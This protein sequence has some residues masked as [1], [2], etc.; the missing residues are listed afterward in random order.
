[1]LIF[2]CTCSAQIC[3]K[4]RPSQSIYRY[5]AAGSRCLTCSLTVEYVLKHNKTHLV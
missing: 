4:F 5:S 1:M 3:L 2:H